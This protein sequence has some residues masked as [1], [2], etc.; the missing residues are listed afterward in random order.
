MQMGGLTGFKDRKGWLVFFGI[1]EIIIGVVCLL[2]LGAMLLASSKVAARTASMPLQGLISAMF[3]YGL[4]AL[5]FI[6]IGIGSILARR[7][8][9]AIMVMVS[10]LWFVFGTVGIIMMFSLLPRIFSGPAMNGEQLQPGIV[11][12][13]KAI[14]V[15][16]SVV[17]FF[18]VPGVLFLFYRS[19]NVKA[20]CEKRDTKRRWTDRPLLVLSLSLVSGFIALSMA[21]TLFSNV[22]PFFGIILTGIPA[23]IYK[24]TFGAVAAWSAWHLYHQRMLGWLAIMGLSVLGLLSWAVT[25]MR[26]GL[27]EMYRVSGMTQEQL[28]QM[29]AVNELQNSPTYW[30]ALFVSAVV[31]FGYLWLVRKELLTV[32]SAP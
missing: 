6:V 25:V 11:V 32:R 15:V 14:I 21:V 3:M 13:V 31:W 29:S 27:L 18:I 7:W 12:V 8:A 19:P 9:R 2:F 1:V 17:L 23:M 4:S 30:L 20:T 22:V 5:F 28:Q 16:I 24:V 10:A 26:G